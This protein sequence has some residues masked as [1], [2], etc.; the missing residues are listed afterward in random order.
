M[1]ACASLQTSHHWRAWKYPMADL[2]QCPVPDSGQHW[3]LKMKWKTAQW[4]AKQWFSCMLCKCYKISYAD[5]WLIHTFKVGSKLPVPPLI[6][7]CPYGF[8]FKITAFPHFPLPPDFLVPSHFQ[9]IPGMIQ[10]WLSEG[11]VC[12]GCDLVRRL[13]GQWRIKGG[14][15]A[16]LSL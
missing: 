12:E 5:R 9:S 10:A 13:C 8:L 3:L 6:L 1:D 14:T 7:H 15:G 11:S 4:I 2:T 16:L